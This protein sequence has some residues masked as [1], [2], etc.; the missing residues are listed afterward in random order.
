MKKTFP[1]LNL[2]IELS[3]DTILLRETSTND[4]LRAKTFKASEV[5]DKYQSLIKSYG[6]KEARKSTFTT[7]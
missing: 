7:K 2:T 4:L 1:K 5:L 3:N 6:E